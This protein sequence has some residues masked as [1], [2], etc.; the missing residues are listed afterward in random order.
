MAP[1]PDLIRVRL[2]VLFHSGKRIE[3]VN[4]I[5]GGEMAAR[6]AFRTAISAIVSLEDDVAA[7]TG[8]EILRSIRAE[9]GNVNGRKMVDSV[10]NVV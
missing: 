6:R 4:G 1:H 8:R 3:Y 9:N 5:S 2:G 7:L 10:T